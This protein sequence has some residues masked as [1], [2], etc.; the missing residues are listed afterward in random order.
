MIAGSCSVK[1]DARL[2]SSQ[3]RLLLTYNGA[4]GC[5]RFG[6]VMSED[7]SALHDKPLRFANNQDP[8]FCVKKG[9][10]IL[11]EVHFATKHPHGIVHQWC[12]GKKELTK[13]RFSLPE[14]GDTNKDTRKLFNAVVSS[15][16]GEFCYPSVDQSNKRISFGN[17]AAI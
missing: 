2:V 1:K 16:V 9:K 17:V 3:G 5:E 14:K 13:T 10:A 4:S 12:E 7:L 6:I 11:T 15:C 8:A